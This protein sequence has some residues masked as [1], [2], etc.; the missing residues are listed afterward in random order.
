MSDL[1]FG[2]KVGADLIEGKSVD[3]LPLFASRRLCLV[4]DDHLSLTS[5]CCEAFVA[6]RDICQSIGGSRFMAWSSVLSASDGKTYPVLV[7]HAQIRGYCL[8]VRTYS[9]QQGLHLPLSS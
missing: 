6:V 7:G 1:V 3:L 2:M 5:L 9:I 4:G 8:F